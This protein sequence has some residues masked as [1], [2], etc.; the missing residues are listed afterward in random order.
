MS[1]S[2]DWVSVTKQSDSVKEYSQIKAMTPLLITELAKHYR[3]QTVVSVAARHIENDKMMQCGA[4]IDQSP[5]LQEILQAQGREAAN[6]AAWEQV[7]CDARIAQSPSLQAISQR[8]GVDAARSAA[9]QERAIAAELKSDNYRE[10]ERES[11]HDAAHEKA[12]QTVCDDYLRVYADV[13]LRKLAKIDSDAARQAAQAILLQTR[14]AVSFDEMKK[15]VTY[16]MA[17]GLLAT[18][19]LI[20]DPS[21]ALAD[22][23]NHQA[24]L[25]TFTHEELATKLDTADKTA[26]KH[27]LKMLQSVREFHVGRFNAL[28]EKSVRDPDLPQQLV[29]FRNE[30][31]YLHQLHDLCCRAEGT[32]DSKKERMAI[33]DFRVGLETKIAY[34]DLVQKTLSAKIEVENSQLTTGTTR[35]LAKNIMEKQGPDHP[36][37]SKMMLAYGVSEASAVCAKT[38]HELLRTALK[39]FTELTDKER[40]GLTAQREQLAQSM[41]ASA[42][43]TRLQGAIEERHQAASEKMREI[44]YKALITA[45]ANAHM[46]D[47]LRECDDRIKM[48]DELSS[49]MRDKG[50]EVA[51]KK[52]WLEIINQRWNDSRDE[53]MLEG[54]SSI[55]AWAS[56]GKTTLLDAKISSQERHYRAKRRSRSASVSV[57]KSAQLDLDRAVRA[58]THSKEQPSERFRTLMDCYDAANATQDNLTSSVASLMQYENLLTSPEAQQELAELSNGTLDL[59]GDSEARQQ[60]FK[61]FA[62]DHPCGIYFKSE[63]KYPTVTAI[64]NF[65]H[66]AMKNLDKAREMA[67][68]NQ[69]FKTEFDPNNLEDYSEYSNTVKEL[70]TIVTRVHELDQE[71]RQ[72]MSTMTREQAR[73]LN[74]SLEM[75]PTL[76][77]IPKQ[78]LAT[79]LGIT[80]AQLDRFAELH[81]LTNAVN[82]VIDM[83]NS[84]ILLK[85]PQRQTMIQQ[86]QA[87]TASL[88]KSVMEANELGNDQVRLIK[89]TERELAT[90]AKAAQDSRDG[91]LTKQDIRMLELRDSFFERIKALPEAQQE[92]SRQDLLSKYAVLD[93]NAEFTTEEAQAIA[94]HSEFVER[95]SSVFKQAV[96][97]QE[98]ANRGF[99]TQYLA[100]NAES[101]LLDGSDA[102]KGGAKGENVACVQTQLVE[103]LIVDSAR[104]IDSTF[105]HA[106][107]AQQRIMSEISPQAPRVQQSTAMLVDEGNSIVAKAAKAANNAE[108][109]DLEQDDKQQLGRGLG[110]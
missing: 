20:D 48:S 108:R 68:T 28:T 81:Q 99:T 62:H 38:K 3:A 98:N 42:L 73:I 87:H 45:E 54:K 80:T 74:M 13:E 83:P 6:K 67:I 53:L 52:A 39:D 92:A 10:I 5:Q 96:Y 88:M 93:K 40:T 107:V 58:L 95:H 65:R 30:V 32:V 56:A 26:Y 60:A 15:E 90:A 101:M 7:N 85:F 16:E 94:A 77:K 31:S 110:S 63:H 51:Q 82:D 22:S 103:A 41:P 2:K 71:V 33:A 12:W 4:A 78:G 23:L 72:M 11:G 49:I 1:R 36:E 43:V 102:Q 105:E 106:A 44:Q 91:R 109:D 61:D 19:A 8:D 9:W 17:S 86:D 27:T 21:A 84:Q 57:S 25:M 47:K 66:L 35:V 64:I 24:G 14:P 97:E 70:S 50:L 69:V 37:A 34:C 89:D 76:E 59:S 46:A 100:E 18:S 104:L 29:T 79:K 55:K 75:I